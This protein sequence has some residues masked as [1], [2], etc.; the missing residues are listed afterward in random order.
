MTI[1]ERARDYACHVTIEELNREGLDA[2]SFCGILHGYIKGATEQRKIDIDKACE[3]LR[4]IL[5]DYFPAIGIIV[6]I[7]EFRKAMEEE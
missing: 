7:D 6:L 2:E 5:P 3:C 1:E 4:N